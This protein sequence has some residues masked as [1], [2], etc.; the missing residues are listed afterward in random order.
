MKEIYSSLSG[1]STYSY[2]YFTRAGLAGDPGPQG[3]SG[4]TGPTGPTG[5]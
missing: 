1:G 5:E 3:P 4:P 2:V